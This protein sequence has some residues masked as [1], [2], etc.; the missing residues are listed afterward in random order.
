MS[1]TVIAAVYAASVHA[2]N[3]GFDAPGTQSFIYPPIF[4]G[5]PWLHW[6]NKPAL[7]LIL[8]I[9]LIFCFFYFGARK[10]ALVPAKFQFAAESLYSFVRD[11]IARDI[12][13]AD[14]IKYVP[15]LVTL[16][17]FILVNN[18]FGIV[19]L[20]QFAPLA[21]V[22]FPIVLA[23]FT[24]LLFLSIGIRR[25]GFFG[26][27]KGVM[28]P[29]GIPWPIYFILAPVELAQVLFIRPFTLAVRLAANMFAGHLLLLLFTLGGAYMLTNDSLVLKVLSPVSFLAAIALTPFEALIEV[30]QAYIF[31][32]LAALYIQEALHPDH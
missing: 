29:A 1:S 23:V 3:S 16:F 4:P 7:L 10:R 31:V 18:I 13:G 6:L 8:S 27:F 22:G 15:Y 14:F 20:L 11:G 19:P 17:S 30:L 2:D 26:Y 25:A 32:L 5:V 24:W 28:F 12:I 21:R 9:V